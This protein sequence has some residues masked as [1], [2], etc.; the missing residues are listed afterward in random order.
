MAKLFIS[1]P[2]RGLSGIE[3]AEIRA[4][5]LRQAFLIWPEED[6]EIMDQ[7]L[8]P[9]DGHKR[10]N[11]H[12]LGRSIQILADADY[13]IGI[14]DWRITDHF[15][16]CRVENEVAGNYLQRESKDKVTC[17]FIDNVEPIPVFKK[18][19]LLLEEEERKR[20]MPVCQ[21]VM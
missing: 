13:Y 10:M 12:C 2:M 21:E 17:Y 18:V 14:S 7:L 16:G 11:V 4:W 9:E 5:M 8:P 15:R 19:L 6:L 3:I 20:L 1:C